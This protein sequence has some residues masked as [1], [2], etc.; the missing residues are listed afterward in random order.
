[1]KVTVKKWGNRLEAGKHKFT[2]PSLLIKDF[3]HPRSHWYYPV[4]LSR[5]S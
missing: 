4:E 3:S 2:R 5:K 1:M